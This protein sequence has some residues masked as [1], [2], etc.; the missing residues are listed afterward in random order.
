VQRV[1][2]SRTS[3][4]DSSVSRAAAGLDDATIGAGVA[5]ESSIG[6]HRDCWHLCNR[7]VSL[8]WIAGVNGQQSYFRY[9]SSVWLLV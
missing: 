4:K 8:A 1:F 9:S 3:Q 2:S 5:T 6:C 7:P